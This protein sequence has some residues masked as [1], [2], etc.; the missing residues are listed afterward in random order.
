MAGRLCRQVPAF[1]ENDS[2]ELGVWGKL[3]FLGGS[4]PLC[5]SA[6]GAVHTTCSK[7]FVEKDSGSL[8]FLQ[9]E[10]PLN[11]YLLNTYYVGS[12]MTMTNET[13]LLCTLFKFKSGREKVDNET[14][15]NF[16]D[17][18]ERGTCFCPVESR[19]LS[20]SV[21]NAKEQFRFYSLSF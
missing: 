19:K 20:E 17:A 8:V 6:K 9:P 12:E 10:Q 11:T 4:Q 14:K 18:M 15:K 1:R 21:I 3:E 16:E 2:L 13:D 5:C 7:V